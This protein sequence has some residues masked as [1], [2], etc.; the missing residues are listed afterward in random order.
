M[1]DIVYHYTT[2]EALLNMAEQGKLRLRATNCD[3][4]NDP[5]EKL[6]AIKV[7]DKYLPIIEERVNILPSNRLSIAFKEVLNNPKNNGKMLRWI[8]DWCSPF[9][10]YYIT[11]F[12]LCADS[13]PMW[14]MYALNGGGIAIGIDMSYLKETYTFMEVKYDNA[15]NES[16]IIDMITYYYARFLKGDYQERLHHLINGFSPLFKNDFYAYE[17]EYRIIKVVKHPSF[18]T[19][20]RTRNGIIIPYI[21]DIEIPADKIIEFIIGPTLDFELAKRSMYQFLSTKRMIHWSG[22]IKQSNVPYR[23]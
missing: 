11:C 19:K 9:E 22:Q 2:A 13:L 5:T 23:V 17:K 3:Y 12:S 6:H 14:N 1:S 10:S 7:L 15:I 20:Y 8:N 21:D 4:L 16:Q 18:S